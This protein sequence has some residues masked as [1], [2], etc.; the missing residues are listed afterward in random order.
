MKDPTEWRKKVAAW[1]NGTP[2]SELFNIPKYDGGTDGNNYNTENPLDTEKQINWMRNWLNARRDVLEKNANAVG[3][4]YSKYTPKNTTGDVRNAGWNVKYYDN[5][6]N[7]FAY[8][9]DSTP[10]RNRINKIIYSQIE[11]AQSVPK[12]S[13]GAGVSDDYNMRGVYVEPNYWDNGGNY[14]AFVGVPDSDVIVHELTHASHPEQQERYILN[15]IFDGRVPQV[16]PLKRNTDLQN[17]KELYGA[18]QQFRYKYNLDPKYKIT[19]EWINKNRDL[20]KGTYLEN[21]KDSYKL[22]L[23]ND[24]AQNNIVANRLYYADKGKSIKPL[25]KYDGGTDDKTYLP[26]Y[27]YEA[28][29]T[30][31]GTSLEKHKRMTNEEDWQKYWG[32]VGAGYVN[33]A[34][35]SVAKPILEGLK[36][37]SYFTPLGNAT[38]AGDLLAANINGD[39]DEALANAAGLLPQVRWVKGVNKIAQFFN[40]IPEKSSFKLLRDVL[41]SPDEVIAARRAGRYPL[42]FSERRDY[43]KLLQ[44]EATDAWYNVQDMQDALSSKY[45]KLFLPGYRIKRPKTIIGGDNIVKRA[46]LSDNSL[47]HYNSRSGDVVLRRR[48]SGSL[49]PIENKYGF[50]GLSAHE[51]QHAVRDYDSYLLEEPF[52]FSTEVDYDK[53]NPNFTLSSLFKNVITPIGA[54]GKNRTAWQMSPDEFLS[55]YWKYR[56][57]SDPSGVLVPQFHKMNDSQKNEVVDFISRRFDLSQQTVRDALQDISFF[58]GYDKGKSIH[59]NPAN[60]GKFKATMKRTGKSAEELSHSKNPLTR[61]RAIFALNSRKFKH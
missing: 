15:N 59:I 49:L 16:V 57:A 52:T 51:Y 47:G 48:E 55:D 56:A 26:E 12:T 60:R 25:P 35:E 28:T 34:Q 18:L 8:F 42:T 39:K 13:V 24:V 46:G 38:A 23:F 3:Y 14:V 36:T 54:S 32:N 40:A 45:P 31:Q 50:K 29:V 41:T 4:G 43:V 2:T 11:N 53:L 19:Q 27:E 37:A 9:N 17:A 33:R 58:G 21:I 61:K 22:K 44:N 1:K 7:P 30:P 6:W 20:F 5:L 10:T